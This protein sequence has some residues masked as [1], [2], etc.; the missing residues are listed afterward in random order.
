MHRQYIDVL[1]LAKLKPNLIFSLTHLLVT[2]KVIL[3]NYDNITSSTPRGN[4]VSSCLAQ[5]IAAK[6]FS[7]S[8]ESSSISST[9]GLRVS[10][11]IFSNFTTLLIMYMASSMSIAQPIKPINSNTLR[12]WCG[13]S[14]LVTVLFPSAGTSSSPINCHREEVKVLCQSKEVDNLLCQLRPL[15]VQRL[16]I[17]LFQKELQNII[18]IEGK[19]KHTK[20]NSLILH[21]ERGVLRSIL[22][23]KSSFPNLG[24]S[25]II[26]YS[27]QRHLQP[28]K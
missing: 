12:H 28:K 27:T 24:A 25:T 15:Q 13:C 6:F 9:S 23:N 10:I 8:L 17:G 22:M 21:L 16:I 5:A 14:A 7:W 1:N 2:K 19:Y 26:P 11:I 4:L 3:Q 20:I 18:T